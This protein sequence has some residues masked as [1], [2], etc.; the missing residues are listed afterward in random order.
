[1][2][3]SKRKIFAS[4]LISILSLSAGCS[5]GGGSSS[6]TAGTGV[7]ASTMQTYS[8][9]DYQITVPKAWNVMRKNE[10]TS[11][12]AQ[13]AVMGFQANRKNEIFLANVNI[14]KNTLSQPT[15]SL[16]YG[17]IVV[18]NQKNILQNFA[19][20]DR[21]ELDTTIKGN[22]QKVLMVKF[23]GKRTTTDPM[24]TFIQTYFVYDKT[25]YI[26]TGSY[27]SSE[28]PDIQKETDNIVQ[29]FSIK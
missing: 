24:I 26:V 3:S 29:S 22:K 12:V 25:V 4:L 19:E 7:E 23:E 1:M 9:E 10:F 17:K 5:F 27:V 2:I 28:D 20:K 13:N 15:S 6:G 8:G 11:D 18:A 14:V 16:D 21:Q